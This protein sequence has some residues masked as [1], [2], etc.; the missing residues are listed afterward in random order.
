MAKVER[1]RLLVPA[2]HEPPRRPVAEKLSH[3]PSR[4]AVSGLLD[5]DDFGPEIRQMFAHTRAGDNVCQLDDPY[6]L[7]RQAHCTVLVSVIPAANP[8][9]MSLRGHCSGALRSQGAR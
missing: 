5:L 2:D 7:E 8:V 6:A 9:V 3:S 4:I 1:D